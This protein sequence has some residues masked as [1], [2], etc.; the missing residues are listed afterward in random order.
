MST[1]LFLVSETRIQKVHFSPGHVTQTA[2]PS[3]CPSCGGT[4]VPCAHLC[5]AVRGH[6]GF[7]FHHPGGLSLGESTAG[8]AEQLS[9]ADSCVAGAAPA[10]RET[11]PTHLCDLFS[12]FPASPLAPARRECAWMA[13][14]MSGAAERSLRCLSSSLAEALPNHQRLGEEEAR[15]SGKARVYSGGMRGR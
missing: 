12:L 9:C 14:G 6:L 3:S 8:A 13:G 15:Q 5:E 7:I 1:S 4:R 11:A 10:R 2:A